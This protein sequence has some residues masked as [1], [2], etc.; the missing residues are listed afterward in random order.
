MFLA[1][2]AKIQTS[3]TVNDVKKLMYDAIGLQVEAKQIKDI[4][5]RR[6]DWIEVEDGKPIKFKLVDI[7]CD[8]ARNIL[9]E[10]Q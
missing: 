9:A 10:Y 7:G 3:F 2:E 6:P 5:Q 1:G 4:L 8:Y